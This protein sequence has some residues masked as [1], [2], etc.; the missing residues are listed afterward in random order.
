MSPRTSKITRNNLFYS[1]KDYL[2]DQSVGESYLKQDIN[3]TILLF[4]VDRNKTVV[5]D[6]YGE[7]S[8]DGVVYKD[9]VELNVAYTIDQVKN[10]SHDKKQN[11]LNYQQIG[12]L[13]F[14]VYIK[15]LNENNIDVDYG[16]YVGVQVTPSQMEYFEVTN[17][18]RLNFD[19][20]HTLFGYKP[21]YR[22]ILC[23][24]VDKSSFKGV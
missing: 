21:L 14:Q 24:P 19:N 9:P 18:G 8:S 17:D 6:L 13:T 11:L 12:N 1:E 16:D 23:V 10:V 22:S 5:D 3:Q 15:T 2:F 20:K 7:T 4:K